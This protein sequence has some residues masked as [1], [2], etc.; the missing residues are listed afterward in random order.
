MK[1]F[2]LYILFLLI[3][4]FL[5]QCR[6]TPIGQTPIEKGKPGPVTITNVEPIAGGAIITYSLPS[7]R[8]LLYVRAEYLRNQ[9]I[10]TTLSS[11]HVNSIRI[12]GLPPFTNNVEVS[13]SAVDNSENESDPIKITAKPL[14][15]PLISI[16]NS[17]NPKADFG[18]FSANWTN[19]TNTEVGITVLYDSLSLGVFKES[20][21][22]YSKK[23]ADSIL[24]EPFKDI[25]ASFKI[26]LTD[27]WGNQSPMKIFELTP[28]YETRL[29]GSSFRLVDIVRDLSRPLNG[30]FSMNNLFDGNL[31]STFI[32]PAQP[33]KKFP[34]TLTFDMGKKVKLSK[35]KLWQWM[36]FPF[37]SSNLKEWE[38]WGTDRI[39]ESKNYD[40]T[41]WSNE[42]NAAWKNDWKRMG[43]YKMF[44]PSGYEAP[45]SAEDITIAS[46]GFLGKFNASN[47]SVRYVRI[48]GTNTMTDTPQWVIS[49]F[50]LW[51]DDKNFK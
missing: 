12:E 17:F 14:E 23:S 7:D 42:V 19:E 1:Q 50:A 39:D 9:K 27:K 28:Y 33:D 49:E 43:I 30:G 4:A 37:A 5:S 47:P 15:S 36:V 16:L 34:I 21:T 46:E 8:D 10:A 31:S 13:L 44:K 48:V 20:M 32:T 24:F 6:E 3:F 51:G 35:H 45:V 26:Y 2:N 29:N 11:S 22:I 25:K 18:G 41:Y 38:I 40:T